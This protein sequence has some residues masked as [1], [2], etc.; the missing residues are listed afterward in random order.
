MKP[1]GPRKATMERLL[2]EKRA[3]A[4]APLLT[5]WMSCTTPPVRVGRYETERV[6][7]PGESYLVFYHGPGLWFADERGVIPHHA[8]V[9]PGMH[10]WRGVRRWVLKGPD[11]N[12]LSLIAGT[13]VPIYLEAARPRSAKWNKLAKARPFR[14]EDEAQRFASRYPHLKATAVLP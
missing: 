8:A 1:Y 5:D 4:A 11:A 7:R 6:D 3:A 14:T 10:R 2:A 12:I 9:N 13:T